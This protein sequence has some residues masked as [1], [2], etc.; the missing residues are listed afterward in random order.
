L[1]ADR[2]LAHFSSERFLFVRSRR[3]F[4]AGGPELRLGQSNEQDLTIVFSDERD[5]VLGRDA[6]AVIFTLP[7]T[8]WSQARLSGASS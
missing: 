6:G 1:L 4:R 2:T 3:E 7:V 8:M 5:R